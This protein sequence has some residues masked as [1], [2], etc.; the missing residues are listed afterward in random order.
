MKAHLILRLAILTLLTT[1]LGCL[2]IGTKVEREIVYVKLGRFD[3]SFN[4]QIRVATNKPIPVTVNGQAMEF[5][6][7]GFILVDEN[8]LKAIKDNQN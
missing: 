5:N 7:G 4:G 2:T 6:A 3:P 1:C 8:D